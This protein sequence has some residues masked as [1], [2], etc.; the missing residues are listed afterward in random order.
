MKKN[1]KVKLLINSIF[2][3]RNIVLS[4]AFL[5]IAYLFAGKLNIPASYTGSV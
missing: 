1:I 4:M 2:Y 3:K 5:L